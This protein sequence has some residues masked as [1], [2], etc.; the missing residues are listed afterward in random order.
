M[1]IN[2]IEEYR[3]YLILA[4]DLSYGDVKEVSGT[5]VE[6]SKLLEAYK[7]SIL[8]SDSS[9]FIRAESPRT[10]LSGPCS[11]RLGNPGVP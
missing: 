11:Y 9:L 6:V 2:G 10:C 3:Y 5:L 7:R 1:K 4:N 8:D